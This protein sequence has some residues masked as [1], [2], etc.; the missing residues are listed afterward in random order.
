MGLAHELVTN[1][2]YWC[3]APFV[4]L[5]FLIAGLDCSE[6]GGSYKQIIQT[7][8]Q[9]AAITVYGHL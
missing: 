5:C 6:W 8:L 4:L 2:L 9:T 3:N 7:L 1:V